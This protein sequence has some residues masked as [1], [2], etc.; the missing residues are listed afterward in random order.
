[1]FNVNMGSILYYI[2]IILGSGDKIGIPLVLL[3]CKSNMQTL[4]ATVAAGLSL[5]QLLEMR[6]DNQK[7]QFMYFTYFI[8]WDNNYA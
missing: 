4:D 1:M 8:V 7:I 3:N 2:Y 6:N 5:W